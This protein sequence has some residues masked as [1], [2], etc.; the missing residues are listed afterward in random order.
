MG[1]DTFLGRPRGIFSFLRLYLQPLAHFTLN[2]FPTNDARVA[3]M[4]FTCTEHLGLGRFPFFHYRN[5]LGFV[6]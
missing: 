3:L 4:H 1:N 6:G 2:R 5:R